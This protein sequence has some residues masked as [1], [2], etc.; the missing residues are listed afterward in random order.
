MCIIFLLDLCFTF[1]PKLPM[2]ILEIID[3]PYIRVVAIMGYKEVVAYSRGRLLEKPRHQH[4]PLLDCHYDR[5]VAT[6][7]ARDVNLS[8]FDHPSSSVARRFQHI[9]SHKN[10]ATKFGSE[11]GASEAGLTKCIDLVSYSVP[12]PQKLSSFTL[13]AIGQVSHCTVPV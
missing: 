11:Y 12:L 9:P 4:P 8:W 2:T 1:L 6:P 13:T 3:A 5:S 7:P 10:D